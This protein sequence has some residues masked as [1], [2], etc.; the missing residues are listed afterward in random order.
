MTLE[1][2]LALWVELTGIDPS[3]EKATYTFKMNGVS[4]CDVEQWNK[5]I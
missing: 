5:K 1:E 3:E 4:D 2:K